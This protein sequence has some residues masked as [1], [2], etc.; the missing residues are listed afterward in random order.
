MEI[1]WTFHIS[2][3][4]LWSEDD[5]GTYRKEPPSF[6]EY[7]TVSTLPGFCT[8]TSNRSNAS[9]LR[10]LL[11]WSRLNSQFITKS[12]FVTWIFAYVGYG[13]AGALYFFRCKFFSWIAKGKF[14]IEG[15][16]GAAASGSPRAWLH[17]Y[18]VFP[19]F[20]VFLSRTR[21]VFMLSLF[22]R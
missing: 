20:P 2:V 21:N 3:S 6:M 11:L 13:R 9:R 17:M 1:R 5:R 8:K 12:L 16:L 10:S 19:T 7:R 14:T 22:V 18:F 15:D 4:F